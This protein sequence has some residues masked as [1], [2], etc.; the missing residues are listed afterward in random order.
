MSTVRKVILKAANRGILDWLPDAGYISL[1]YFALMGKLPDLRHPRSFNEKLQWL[2]LHD[3]NPRYSAMVD[4]YEAKKTAAER[5]GDKYIIP[6][7]GLWENFGDINFDAL[8]RQFVLK[9]THDSGGLVIC[10]DQAA[11]DRKAAKDRIEKSMKRNYFLKSREWP[12]RN[13]SPRILAEAYLQGDPVSGLTDYKVFCFHGTPKFT[14]V[15]RNRFGQG[16]LTEDF[17]DLDWHLMPMGRPGRGHGPELPKPV[18]Y[19]EMLC[20]AAAL[21]EN[22]PFLRVDFYDT[23]SGL[24]FGEFTFYPSS[25]FIGFE[26]AEWDMKLGEWIDLSAVR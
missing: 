20:L 14:L 2:K 9:C 10:G 17:Y 11:L 24:Y 12:Y 4:K 6:T 15:C 3:R 18:H 1:K 22:I 19:D 23:P 8:P 16:G 7:L 5:I 25:G 13:V 26:P 21:S